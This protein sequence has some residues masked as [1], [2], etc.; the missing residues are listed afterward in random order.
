M[1]GRL[2]LII[3]SGGSYMGNGPDGF[4]VAPAR[5]YLNAKGMTV[6]TMRYRA[7]ASKANS[8]RSR[9][10][11]TAS[12]AWPRRVRAATRGWTASGSS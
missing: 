5:R 12:S 7:W 2:L 11:R 4:E 10:V 1:L 3:N 9:S 6:V 8:T